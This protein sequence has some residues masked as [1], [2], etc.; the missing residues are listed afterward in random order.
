MTVPKPRLDIDTTRDRLIA[1]GCSY[2][3]EQLDTVLS[4]AV[5]QRVAWR[6]KRQKWP[7][8]LRLV[9]RRGRSPGDR[10]FG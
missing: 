5:R 8:P 3:A 10:A 6:R 1:L 4:E 9:R 2:A 7:H